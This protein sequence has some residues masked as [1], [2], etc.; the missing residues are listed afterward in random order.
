MLWLTWRQHRAQALGTVALLAGAAL[1]L[2]LGRM[3]MDVVKALPMV[4]VFVGLFWGVPLLARE[5]E[6]GTDRL[7]WTQ[8]VPRTRW[9]TVKFTALGAAVTLAGLAFGTVVLR[10][11][12]SAGVPIDRFSGD[13]FGVTGVASGAWFLTVFALGAASGAVLRRLLPA[14]AVTI[15]V[16]AGLVVGAYLA[17]EHYAEPEVAVSGTRGAAVPAGALVVGSGVL[18]ADGQRLTWNEAMSACEGED[19]VSCLRDRG[20]DRQYTLYQP[21]GRYWRFQWTETGLLLALTLVLT[22]VAARQV[23]SRSR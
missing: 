22:G 10:W 11:T 2:V 21:A 1:L 6:R 17:R 9:L 14:M 3:P 19:P 4:P 16:F 15:A 18:A 23:V 5:Y 12:A 13:V 8:S 20:Y 7:V